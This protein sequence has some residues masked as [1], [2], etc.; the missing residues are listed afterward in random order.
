VDGQLRALFAPDEIVPRRAAPTRYLKG[1]IQQWLADAKQVGEGTQPVLIGRADC[2]LADQW[3]FARLPS[4]VAAA[5]EQLAFDGVADLSACLS[6]PI[7]TFRAE[8]FR[9]MFFGDQGMIEVKLYRR[10]EQT[11]VVHRVLG[12]SPPG[13]PDEQRPLYA[14][15]VETF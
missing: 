15:A 13:A 8:Y 3:L 7:A 14:L 11:L 4:L 9:P 12:M 6:K 5:R 1:R 2:E 10:G